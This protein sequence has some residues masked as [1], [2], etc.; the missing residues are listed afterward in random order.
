MNAPTKVLELIGDPRSGLADD[1][2]HNPFGEITVDL[3]HHQFSNEVYWYKYEYAGNVLRETHRDARLSEHSKNLMYILRAKD[4]RRWTI[5]ALAEKFH[6]RK[7]RV[8]A[9]LALKEME[10]HRMESGKVLQGPLSAYACPVKLSDV[11]LDGSGE[12]LAFSL[13]PPSEST[14]L[15]SLQQQL[16]RVSATARDV[17]LQLLQ[18]L[19]PYGYSVEAMQ[20]AVEQEFAKLEAQ[21]LALVQPASAA[22][23]G[24]GSE[25]KQ[26]GEASSSGEGGDEAA[27]QT[28]S[29]LRAPLQSLLAA[30][31]QVLGGSSVLKEEGELHATAAHLQRLL[32]EQASSSSASSPPDSAAV[33]DGGLPSPP[34]SPEVVELVSAWEGSRLTRLVLQLPAASRKLLLDTV[35]R[36]SA[37]LAT[38]GLDLSALTTQQDYSGPSVSAPVSSGEAGTEGLPLDLLDYQP[39][40][41]QALEGIASA[42]QQLE[43]AMAGLGKLAGSSQEAAG[44]GDAALG[45]EEVQQA[46]AL[47]RQYLSADAMLA[48]LNSQYAAD[49]GARSNEEKK[50][51]L[52]VLEEAAPSSAERA[53]KYEGIMQLI[54]SGDTAAALLGLRELE[55]SEEEALAVA[56]AMGANVDVGP[57]GEQAPNT[58]LDPAA[59]KALSKAQAA[60]GA[61]SWDLVSAYL[62]TQV[63]GKLYHRG[64]GERH[65]VRLSTYPAFE[66]YSLEQYDKL[67]EGELSQLNRL[68]A[69]REEAELYARF[70]SDLLFNLGL[71]GE[72]L[73]DPSLPARAPNMGSRLE[74]PLVVYSIGEDGTTQ[75]PPLYVAEQDGTKRALNEQERVYQDRR[76][77]RKLIAYQLQ[78]IRRKP[79]IS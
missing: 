57:E 27:S 71:V 46:L 1:V 77:Q 55:G 28:A 65:V 42:L 41:R 5:E 49:R 64:S 15:P 22:S 73:W 23:S 53:L 39:V 79:E 33:G 43:Q 11:Q 62:D 35:P 47:R 38:Q 34:A 78:R 56:R 18:A 45:S 19:Q 10:A 59:H 24:E 51:L 20:K 9:I 68:M 66:G 7:Q 29:S 14:A 17:Q 63:A 69:E 60:A 74:A 6:I 54:R 21:L 48:A 30:A 8:L 70:R 58:A 12:P 40:Q 3:I 26:E 44:S 2:T 52:K 16:P 76:R 61:G 32:Q 13:P 37:E 25:P 67:E 50:A 75:Y 4:P 31:R 72:K 36:V